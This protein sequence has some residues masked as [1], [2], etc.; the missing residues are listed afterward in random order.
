MLIRSL[1]KRRGAW[2]E[3]TDRYSDAN[4]IWTQIKFYDIY[5]LQKTTSGQE[6]KLISLEKGEKTNRNRIE[7]LKKLGTSYQQHSTIFQDS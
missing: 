1:F 3:F 5:R 7:E 2:W 4:F 6:I